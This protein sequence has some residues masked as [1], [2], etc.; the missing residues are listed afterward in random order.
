M[1]DWSKEALVNRGYSQTILP[2]GNWLGIEGVWTESFDDVANLI[3]VRKT[4]AA[5]ADDRILLCA[6]MEGR[7]RA[8]VASA[9]AGLRLASVELNYQLTVEVADDVTVTVLRYNTP[10]NTVA[11]TSTALVG[12]Y[13]AAHDTAGE[14]GAIAS[15]SLVFNITTPD[16]FDADEALM[17]LVTVNDVTGGNAVFDLRSL[18]LHWNA[19]A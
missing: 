3:R 13:A 11:A 18:V 12:T 15:H 8:G 5:N 2:P 16:Y 19:G 4:A 10:A 17:V 6:P 7:S 14:R 9:S 1:P